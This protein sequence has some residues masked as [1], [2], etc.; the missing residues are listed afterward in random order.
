MTSLDDIPVTQLKGVGSALAEK[1]AKLGIHSLQDLLFHLPHRYEDRTRVTPM[2]RLRIGD[3]TVVEGEVM[4]SDLVMGRRRSLQVTL[5]DDS[6]FLVMRF[7]HFNAAQKN[8]LAEGARVRCFGEVR[9]GR[10]GYE[11]YH[12]EYQVNPPPMPA[13]GE[14]TLTPVYPLTEGIQQPRVRGLCQQAL[15]YLQRYPI[16]DWLPPEL[17]SDYQ[18]PGITD[19]VQLVHSPPAS[20]P[21]HLLMEGRHPAQ[22]RLVMEE[23]LA[24]QLS[25]LQ[26]REQI[27]A[28]EALPL[29]PAGDLVQRF[30]ESLPFDLTG[31]QRH[32]LSDIRQD[33]S[34][35]VPMLRLVQGDVGSGKTVVAALAALQ[36]L[37]AGAQV[38]L[39]APTEIL[40]E[41]HYRNFQEWMTPLGIQLAWLSGKVKGKVRR[42]TLAAVASGEAQVVIGTHALFQDDVQFQRLALVIVDEQHRFGVHQ[43]L[44]LREKGVGGALAPHQLIMTATPIPRT[45]AMSAYADLDTSVIDELPPGRKP[46]ETIVIPDNRREDVVERVRKACLEGRQAYWVCTLIEESEALQCQAAEATAEELVER[47]PELKVGL[48]HGRLKASEKADVMDRFKQGELDLLVAT[49]VIEVGVDVP[50]A[51]LI[52][53]ENPERLGLAQLHQLRGRVGRGEQ[54][55]FCVLMYHPPLSL[56]GKARL[57]ALRDSQDGFFIAEK[58]LEIRGPGEVLG[59]RQTGMMQ[60]RL[61][62]FERDKGWIEPVREMAPSLM[63]SPVIVEG[64]IRRWLGERIRYGD[65]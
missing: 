7:F 43:R 18:L 63:R 27:Q 36:A 22:Q 9:P 21:V 51:S 55:S 58:D 3:L 34:Q 49:T 38:A 35:P 12:P 39:M 26:V 50:N 57:Q 24:H 44:A 56:N 64:L 45:L 31:A 37:G 42:E 6:G 28:R 23:L 46:I 11:F 53:I 29:L 62:D 2:G 19:A 13:D 8:Q 52:L 65:V 17:L 20:A 1:F 4:K 25:L 33:L 40:A 15:V 59:T 5:K 48:V 41:Q 14:A 30:Q 32:V 10:A 16:K 60:F 61:A 54:A 47:L